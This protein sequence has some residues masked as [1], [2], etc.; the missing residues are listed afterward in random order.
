M[1][2]GTTTFGIAGRLWLKGTL[3]H[4]RYNKVL[5]WGSRPRM[6]VG[7]KQ[8]YHTGQLGHRIRPLSSP[9]LRAKQSHWIIADEEDEE[10]ED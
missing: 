3:F 6:T 5:T 7:N 4:C 9:N 2:H 8:S 1:K 10:E